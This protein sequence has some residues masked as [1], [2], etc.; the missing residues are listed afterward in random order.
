MLFDIFYLS[1]FADKKAVDSVVLRVVAAAVV[2]SAARYDF[3]VRVFAY[4]EVV[5]NLLLKTALGHNDG[6]MN[7]FVFCTFLY[8][9][10]NS[11]DLCFGSNGDISGGLASD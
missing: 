7:A 10:I 3:H 5:I 4:I 9:Y 6:D 2:D 8:S 11:A 1:V